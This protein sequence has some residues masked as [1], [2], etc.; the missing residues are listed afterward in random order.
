MDGANGSGGA[1]HSMVEDA[2]A[3]VDNPITTRLVSGTRMKLR[4]RRSFLLPDSL[5]ILRNTTDR[6]AGRCSTY[7]S[8]KVI[9]ATYSSTDFFRPWVC[10]RTDNPFR[11]I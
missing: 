1:V 3:V 4:S 9:W 2:T 8:K 5:L 11:L 10:W 7:A 6:G